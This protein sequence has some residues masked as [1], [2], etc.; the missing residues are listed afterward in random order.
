MPGPCLQTSP[1]VRTAVGNL[2]DIH[3]RKSRMANYDSL[4]AS[5]RNTMPGKI[6]ATNQLDRKFMDDA[7]GAM[8]RR[9]V[10][11]KQYDEEA[12]AYQSYINS[13]R[14]GVARMFSAKVRRDSGDVP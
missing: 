6:D 11:Q 4:L 7:A 8:N 13:W 9:E 10:A 14:G 3:D 2:K 1:E 12:A 5:F